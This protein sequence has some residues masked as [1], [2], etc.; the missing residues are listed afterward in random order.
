M[1]VLHTA[2]LAKLTDACSKHSGDY[3][4]ALLQRQE[5]ALRPLLEWLDYLRTCE[6]TGTADV[7]LDG[8]H[9]AAVEASGCLALG[10]VRPALLAM[11]AEIDMVLAWIYF[12]DHPAEWDLVEQEGEGFKLKRELVAY[13]E[14]QTSVYPQFKARFGLLEQSRTR[15]ETDPY[16]LLSAH[17]HSQ[18]T[19]TVPPLGPLASLVC[20][21]TLCEDCVAIQGEVCEYLNDILFSCFADKWGSLPESVRRTTLDR[22]TD[23]QRRAFFFPNIK[24]R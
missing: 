20:S 11:R 14:T 8:V 2:A 7:M 13:C 12:K 15:R 17:L 21:L 18:G 5:Q 3:G 9:A 10:L 1:S 24:K 6:A 22:L 16:R 4:P 19:K 23:E